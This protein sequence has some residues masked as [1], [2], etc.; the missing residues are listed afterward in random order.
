MKNKD[1][2]S[3]A[4]F[5]LFSPREGWVGVIKIIHKKKY[6]KKLDKQK[7]K[8]NYLYQKRKRKIKKRGVK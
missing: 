4:F 3:L 2:L 5:L 1:F 7:K 6:K 8:S